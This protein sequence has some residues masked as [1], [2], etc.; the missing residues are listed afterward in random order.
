MKWIPA[1]GSVASTD[2]GNNREYRNMVLMM[3]CA[4][5]SS[6]EMKALFTTTE[7]S[8]S[9]TH[10][11]AASFFVC[12]WHHVLNR[13]RHQGDDARGGLKAQWVP[14]KGLVFCHEGQHLSQPQER[15][16][17]IRWEVTCHFKHSLIHSKCWWGAK[18]LVTQCGKVENNSTNWKKPV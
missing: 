9:L 13:Q 17:R 4:R 1:Q 15:E 18:A 3:G 8:I 10:A 5:K 12:V 7:P 6:V 16:T 11:T 2:G 14:L